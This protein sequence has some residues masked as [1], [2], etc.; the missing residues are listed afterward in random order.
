MRRSSGSPAD[1]L[2]D[3]NARGAT[4]PFAV[5]ARFALLL[6]GVR[7]LSVAL[8]AWMIWLVLRGASSDAVFPPDGAWASLG[9]LPAN[10][11]CLWIL[12]RSCRSQ[13]I[14]LATAVG[15]RPDRLSGDVRRA[16][17]WMLLIAGPFLVAVVV[18]LLAMFGAEAPAAFMRLLVAAASVPES[19]PWW[20]L[21]ATVV[22]VIP[23]LL[24]N[25]AAEELVYRGVGLAGFAGLAAPSTT[26]GGRADRRVRVA[27]GTL[28][29]GV[30]FGAQHALFAGSPEGA[31]VYFVGFTVWGLMASLAASRE[32]RLF[33]VVLAHLFTNA[34]LV[35]PGAAI[36]VLRLAGIDLP[37]PWG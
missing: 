26:P 16:G 33:P 6:I 30:L 29:V 34:L 31:V 25:A 4:I 19:S 10:L 7:L 35:I 37:L 11:L 3:A 28:L 17:I 15:Y 24:T 23:F 20:L 13:G 9:L 1:P 2:A 18:T 12:R 5:P 27:A 21:V 14:D 22:A 8:S 36:P 32:G